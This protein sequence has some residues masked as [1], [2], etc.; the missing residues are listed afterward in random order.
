MI[1]QSAPSGL[2][3]LLDGAIMRRLQ[4]RK[5]RE[6][7][8]RGLQG[9]QGEIPTTPPQSNQSVDQPM[10]NMAQGMMNNGGQDSLPPQ[11]GNPY[12]PTAGQGWN[13]NNMLRRKRQTY[14]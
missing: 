4:G 14:L 10:Q 9:M 11:D 1:N 6:Q 2:R 13:L 3:A 12:S 8:M 7:M 5:K